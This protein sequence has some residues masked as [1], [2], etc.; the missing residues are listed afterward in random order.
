MLKVISKE[1]TKGNKSTKLINIKQS[2]IDIEIIAKI[3]A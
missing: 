1:A 3:K 2:L